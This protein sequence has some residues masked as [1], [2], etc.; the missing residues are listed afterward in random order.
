M[1]H[2]SEVIKHQMEET[3]TA[4]TEKLETLE[5]QVVSTVH[6][7]TSA[8]ADT[9]EAVKEAV[10]DSVE[11][12]KGSVEET[13]ET[14]RETLD[15]SCQVQRR[16]WTMMAGS[17]LFGFVAGSLLG[18]AEQERLRLVRQGQLRSEP[19]VSPRGGS[20]FEGSGR[21]N[22][23]EPA[24]PTNGTRATESESAVSHWMGEV[25]NTFEKEINKV[26]GLAIGTL[27]GVV[28]DII[29]PSVPDQLKP[30]LEDVMNSITV[31]LGGQPIRGPIL[32]ELSAGSSRT[33]GEGCGPHYAS[34]TGR[35]MASTCR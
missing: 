21:F 11:M 31:K 23:T 3:R 22:F 17:V 32:Q 34:E 15:L 1:D 16:P 29:T 24:A 30:D 27:V 8:V 5:Q 28:R 35:T 10:H 7:T 25:G 12:V 2:E 14:V 9:V 33:Q 20:R 19:D 26:K 6:S 13:V 18:R 4:L